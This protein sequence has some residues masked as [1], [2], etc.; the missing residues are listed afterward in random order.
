MQTLEDIHIVYSCFLD[1]NKSQATKYADKKRANTIP[2]SNYR[3]NERGVLNS[4]EGKEWSWKEKF[5]NSFLM[6]RMVLIQLFITGREG[7]K[8]LLQRNLYNRSS[9]A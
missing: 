7:I 9:T 2:L 5:R 3:A 8:I 1:V 6:M 4:Y